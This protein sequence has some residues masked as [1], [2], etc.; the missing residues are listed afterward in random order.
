[1]ESISGVKAHTIRIWEKRYDIITPKRTESNIRY[2]TDED[3]RHLL[4]VVLLNKKGYKISKIA[5]MSHEEI[6]QKVNSY[7][8]IN[9]GVDDKVDA[10]ML[11][12]LDLDSYNFNKVLDQNIDQEGL[13]TTMSNLIYPLL[14]KISLAWLAGSFSGVH[15]SFVTQIIK[16]KIQKCIEDLPDENDYRPSY[17]IYLAE[18]EKEELSL[19]Y[20][21]YILKNQ[22]CHVI[23]LG[24]E[25]SLRD[26]ILACNTVNPD[27]IFT[28]INKEMPRLTLQNYVD[29]ICSNMSESSFLITGYQVVA[30][31]IDWPKEVTILRDLQSTVEFIHKSKAQKELS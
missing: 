29:Q 25:V 11:F 18:G 20:L 9:I 21:H 3:L 8:N 22:K 7:S 28:I 26:V 27:Y 16:S 13:E 19:L 4:N 24:S 6:R 2:Y 10:M 31:M 23:N 14:D 12:I 5:E 17:L 30:Q 1:M 15:E